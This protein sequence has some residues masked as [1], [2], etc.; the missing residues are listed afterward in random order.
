MHKTLIFLDTFISLK[1][2]DT[3]FLRTPY[4]NK[5]FCWAKLR[6][7]AGKIWNM[8]RTAHVHAI[9]AAVAVNVVKG[10][11]DLISAPTA[12]IILDFRKS[13]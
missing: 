13:M 10:G 9:T 4:S 3:K 2:I 5:Y 6:L 8:R 11:R 7:T 12:A 1:K